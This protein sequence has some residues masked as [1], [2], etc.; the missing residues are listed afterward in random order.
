MLEIPGFIFCLTT[1]MPAEEVAPSCWAT[2]LYFFFSVCV[3]GSLTEGQMS[4]P[5]AHLALPPGWVDGL[6]LHFLLLETVEVTSEG[7]SSIPGHC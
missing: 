5:L 7:Y 2:F 6:G 3:D 4:E 1:G